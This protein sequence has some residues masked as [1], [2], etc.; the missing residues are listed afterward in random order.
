[1][2]DTNAT[3]RPLNELA[4][5]AHKIAVDHGWWDNPPTFGDV[6]ALCHSELSEALQSYRNNEPMEFYDVKDDG[7][8]TLEGYGVELVDTMIRILDFCGAVG[9]DVDAIMSEKMEYNR[10]RPYRH[11]G[12][13]L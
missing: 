11:G 12:T 10:S 9:L 8:T 6:V 13:R 3:F 7:S 4:L 1:M 5:E 2:L